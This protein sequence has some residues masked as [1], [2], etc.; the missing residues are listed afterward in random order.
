MVDDEQV[1]PGDEI[2]EQGFPKGPQRTL[3]PLD[4]DLGM[5][6]AERLAVAVIGVKPR[7]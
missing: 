2:V 6:I 5:Q 7:E 3:F 4:F 1:V